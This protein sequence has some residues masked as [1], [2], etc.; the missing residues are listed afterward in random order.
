M[1]MKTK[2]RTGPSLATGVTR[3]RALVLLRP[4]KS[5]GCTFL[6]TWTPIASDIAEPPP[7]PGLD[8]VYRKE[9]NEGG[10]EHGDRYRSRTGIVIFLDLD[11]NQQRH[12]LGYVRQ[13]AGDEYDRAI[14]ADAARE[15]EGETGQERWREHRQDDA[16]QGCD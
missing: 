7:A 10:N 6:C 1:A 14:F 13:I 11:H 9:N 3:R 16:T 8:E 2:R 5:A 12:D 4:V 15:R